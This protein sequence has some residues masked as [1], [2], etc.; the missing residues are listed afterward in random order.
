[1]QEKQTN[2]KM[3]NKTPGSHVQMNCL[4]FSSMAAGNRVGVRENGWREGEAGTQRGVR[5]QRS[6]VCLWVPV[7][8]PP[9]VHVKMKSAKRNVY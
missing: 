8:G 4:S 9:K 2:K 1:M 6:S 5:K 3:N 7:G